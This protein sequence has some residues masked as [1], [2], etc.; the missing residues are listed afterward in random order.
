MAEHTWDIGGDDNKTCLYTMTK[1]TEESQKWII[2]VVSTGLLKKSRFNLIVLQTN[3][4]S[5]LE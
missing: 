1:Y 4:A 2:E 3:L 5:M